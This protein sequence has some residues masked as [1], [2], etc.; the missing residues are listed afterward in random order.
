MLGL[1][2]LLYFNVLQT[3]IGIG[4]GEL[5]IGLNPVL[6]LISLL[7][8]LLSFQKANAY[9]FKLIAPSPTRI[10][11]AQQEEVAQFKERFSPKSTVELNQLIAANK[12]VPAA[13]TAA[14]QLVRER[15]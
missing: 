12:L 5:S 11:R 14:R 2:N 10:A 3:N 4:F 9:F 13:L 8:Y 1:F 15:T 6:L 7:A